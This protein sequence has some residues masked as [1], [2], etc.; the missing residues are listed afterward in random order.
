MAAAERLNLEDFELSQTYQM[1]W[2]KLERWQA[3]KHLNA[4]APAS[5]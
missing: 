1:F 4:F 5:D 2:D 3:D